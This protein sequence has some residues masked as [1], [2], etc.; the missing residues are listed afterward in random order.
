VSRA[1]RRPA[2]EVLERRYRRLL[3]TYPADYRAANADDMLGVAL[4]RS[5]AGRRWPELSEAADLIVSGIRMRL[6]ASLRGHSWRDPAAILA[7]ACPLLIAATA[8][9]FI[10]A[11]AWV[12]LSPG[13]ITLFGQVQGLAAGICSAAWWTLVAAAGMAR[14][15]R[16][17]L[18]VAVVGLIWQ[19]IWLALVST[20]QPGVLWASW[21]ELALALVAAVTALA[22]MQSEVRLLSW[23]ASTAIAIAAAVLAAWPAVENA[24]VTW[25]RSPSGG[26]VESSSLVGFVGPLTDGV[27][28]CAVIVALAAFIRLGP[29]VRRRVI[30]VLLPA[31]VTTALVSW[32]WLGYMPGWLASLDV[33]YSG[34]WGMFELVPATSS[35]A[36]LIWLYGWEYLRRTRAK[37]P[38]AAEH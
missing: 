38:A 1:G 15:P 14:W 12:M 23:P 28:G 7:V 25:R 27:L 22:C 8:A 11:P 37:A 6:V 26:W 10:S 24:S 33:F 2:A 4:A 34:Q 17:A 16:I 13:S 20:G 3:A 29:D 9:R 30:V 35:A 31:I 18:A 21:W 19:A 32:G 5:A 36:G